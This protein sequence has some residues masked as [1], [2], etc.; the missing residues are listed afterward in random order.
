M[1]V[2]NLNYPNYVLEIYSIIFKILLQIRSRRISFQVS[3]DVNSKVINFNLILFGVS[4]S[5]FLITNW[6]LLRFYKMIKLKVPV[7]SS[8]LR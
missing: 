2:N 7:A 1:A 4:G 3:S 5:V 6:T 8:K